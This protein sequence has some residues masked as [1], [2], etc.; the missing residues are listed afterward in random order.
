M[1][2]PCAAPLTCSEVPEALRSP[3]R[4]MA[5]LVR[6]RGEGWGWGWG[7]GSGSGWGW[8]Q[9]WGLS[10]VRRMACQF[11]GAEPCQA[12]ALPC[13]ALRASKAACRSGG[14]ESITN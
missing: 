7:Y 8:G 2:V 5:C 12:K 3:V 10:P 14:A 1:P 4:R 11:S 13:L 9:G 6:G